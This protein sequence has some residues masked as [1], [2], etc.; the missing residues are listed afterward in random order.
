MPGLSS[1]LESGSLRRGEPELSANAKREPDSVKHITA[2]NEQCSTKTRTDP[3]M[4]ENIADVCIMFI[5]LHP[6]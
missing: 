2:C 5:V 3:G 4:K 1:G 6:T